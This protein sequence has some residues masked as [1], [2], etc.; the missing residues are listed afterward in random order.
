MPMPSPAPEK[1]ENLP[2]N[3]VCNV[4]VPAVI[5]AKFSGA[6]WLGPQWGLIVAL[7]FPVG[8]G[9][10]DFARRRRLNFISAI[11]FLSVLL[12]GGLGLLKVDGFWF[13]V[14]DAAVPLIIGA[15]VLASM[16]S[17]Q[18]LLRTLLL[19]DSLLDLPRV[20]AALRERRAEG[21]F[22]A[23]VRQ[24]T[25]LVAAAFLISGTLN[26]FLAR[27]LLRSPGG[28]PEFNAELAKMHVWSWPVI[29]VPSMVMLMLALWRLLKGL[30]ALTGL[31]AEAIFKA[32]PPK[33]A[34]TPV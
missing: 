3:L 4:A 34:K 19:N 18:P 22:A 11:G 14:K 23:L 24:A 7:A 25:W 12:T 8:Y 21:A 27:H 15:A 1:R 33:K 5:M 16:K 31:N 32:P 26:Y 17:R 29:V 13:A 6:A 28:T 2:I 30:E 20:D 9:L 10:H